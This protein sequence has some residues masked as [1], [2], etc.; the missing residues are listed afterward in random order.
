MLT[1]VFRSPEG[2]VPNLLALGYVLAGFPV[3]VALLAAAPWWLN[4]AG[5]V[6]TSHT[7]VL[8]AYFVHEFA[9]Q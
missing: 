4:A 2:A 6:L 3:G 9:H 5:V 1:R 7:L 8:A